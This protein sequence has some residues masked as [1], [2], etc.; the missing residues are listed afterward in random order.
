MSAIAEPKLSTDAPRRRG[1]PRAA[2]RH[3]RSP[4]ARDWL[5]YLALRAA[6]AALAAVPLAVALRAGEF[7]A[8]A[9]YVL[10]RPHRRIG[11]RNL[12]I[13]FRDK[14]PRAR[15]RILRAS[16]LNLGRMAAELAHLPRLSS[17]RLQE[18]VRFVDEDWWREAVSWE[19]STGVLALSGHFGNWELL[20]FAHGMRGHP[21]HMVHRAIANPLIDR[22]LNAL[23]VRAGTRAIRKRHAARAV[24]AALHEHGFLVLPFDQNSTR[25]LGV[26]VDFFGEA[27]STNAGIARIALRTDAPIVPIFIVRDGRRA[28]HAVHV[29]PIMQVERTGDDQADVVRNTQRFSDVFED[30]VRRYPEQWLWMHKRWK[31]RPAGAPRLY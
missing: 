14:T 10:D 22:W 13:A 21:V 23:R 15:R 6:F 24:L 29:L 1:R 18:M 9:A 20:V 5:E 12:E 2:V 8:L 3:E 4:H 31:T 28:R 17:E 19:R 26:F 11:M 7:A 25:G 30:M 27:A 16:F